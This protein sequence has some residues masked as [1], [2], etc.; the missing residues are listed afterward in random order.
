M[1]VVGRLVTHDSVVTRVRLPSK[2]ASEPNNAPLLFGIHEVQIKKNG[3]D[4]L[5]AERTLY[6]LQRGNNIEQLED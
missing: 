5:Q 6:K 1:P 4:Q 3:F 2:P